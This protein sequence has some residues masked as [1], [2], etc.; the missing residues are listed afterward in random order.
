MTNVNFTSKY[1]ATTT[2]QSPTKIKNNSRREMN[3]Q[4]E[5]EKVEKDIQWSPLNFNTSIINHRLYINS[6]SVII[7][8]YSK[9]KEHHKFCIF[10]TAN[11]SYTYRHNIYSNL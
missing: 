9:Q 6:L 1:A 8:V 7:Y 10:T 5:N 2:K 11:I 4:C 3:K